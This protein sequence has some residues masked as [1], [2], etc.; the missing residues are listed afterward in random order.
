MT[1]NGINSSIK[2]NRPWLNFSRRQSLW[3]YL[4]VVP[5][6]AVLLALVAYPFFYASYISFTD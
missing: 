1:A 6:L 5:A 4:L 3:G 2:E